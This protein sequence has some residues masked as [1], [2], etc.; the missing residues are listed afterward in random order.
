MYES[1][2][3]RRRTSSRRLRWLPSRSTSITSPARPTRTDHRRRATS[4]GSGRGASR[5]AAPRAQGAAGDPCHH[6]RPRTD[7]QWG[8]APGGSAVRGGRARLV[9]VSVG[10]LAALAGYGAAGVLGPDFAVMREHARELVPATATRAAVN[11]HDGFYPVSAESGTAE[12]ILEDGDATHAVAGQ[13]SAH[14]WGNVTQPLA[15][16]CPDRGA[17]RA[18]RNP[19]HRLSRRRRQHHFARRR[20][21]LPTARRH[22]R[23]RGGPGGHGRRVGAA[24]PAQ[25]L[26][27]AT[28]R[29]PETNGGVGVSSTRPAAQGSAHAPAPRPPCPA[30]PS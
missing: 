11:G 12:F 20:A 1:R 14:G 28:Q 16:R 18:P 21:G 30:W 26:M 5:C 19:R 2:G 6:S 4:L 3:A 13:L 9:V 7:R 24:S 15:R 10:V 23:R 22:L 29:E 25:W 27:T 8:G 17:A